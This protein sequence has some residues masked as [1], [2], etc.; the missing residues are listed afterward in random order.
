MAPAPSTLSGRPSRG[1][2]AYPIQVH[3]TPRSKGTLPAPTAP[4]ADLLC[5][6][7][8]EREPIRLRGKRAFGGGLVTPFEKRLRKRHRREKLL[9]FTFA[10]RA[11]EAFKALQVSSCPG[12]HRAT[13][14]DGLRL[15]ETATGW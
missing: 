2:C 3:S 9:T 7:V 11:F 12:K 10:S 1:S 4:A 14:S 8:R 13:H 15:R 5:R 6:A